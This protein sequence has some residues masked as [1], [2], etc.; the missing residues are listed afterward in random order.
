MCPTTGGTAAS[1]ARESLRLP[2]HLRRDLTGPFGVGERSDSSN[3]HSRRQK[4]LRTARN[5]FHL[6]FR[7]CADAPVRG[8]IFHFFTGCQERERLVG[9]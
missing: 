3:I 1:R 7:Q 6:L 9:Q 4:I 8:K 5:N 2:L